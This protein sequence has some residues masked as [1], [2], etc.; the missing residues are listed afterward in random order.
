MLGRAALGRTLSDLAPD[1]VYRAAPVTRCA[2]GLL[3][4]LFTL[5]RNPDEPGRAVC[6]LWH[7]PA[8]F[9][10]WVLPII[11]LCGARTFLAPRPER[12]RPAVTRPTCP[13]TSLPAGRPVRSRDPGSLDFCGC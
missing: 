9:P 1:G 2:G 6:F 12:P 5:T 7:C 10:E 8:G 4:H 3:H 13:R 11:L